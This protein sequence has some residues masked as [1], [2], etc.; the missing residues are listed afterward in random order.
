VRV[1]TQEA[2][3]ISEHP[4]IATLPRQ[5]KIDCDKWAPKASIVPMLYNDWEPHPACLIKDAIK[6]WSLGTGLVS[7][8][9]TGVGHAPIQRMLLVRPKTRRAGPEKPPVF[10]SRLLSLGSMREGIH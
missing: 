3:W 10:N 8:N 6:R 7:L 4:G 5:S 1:K 9:I 2:R